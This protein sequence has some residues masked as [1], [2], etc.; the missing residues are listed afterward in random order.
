MSHSPPS[1]HDDLPLTLTEDYAKE[2]LKFMYENMH[3]QLPLTD[4]THLAFDTWFARDHHSDPLDDDDQALSRFKMSIS[5]AKNHRKL[6]LPRAI[7]S[8]SL[9]I[10]TLRRY[11]MSIIFTRVFSAAIA[12]LCDSRQQT[13][14]VMFKKYL[15]ITC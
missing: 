1:K 15:S 3:S 8:D 5:L 14:N 10:D 12:Q 2:A 9:N 11:C 6:S 7:Q 13:V 4:L